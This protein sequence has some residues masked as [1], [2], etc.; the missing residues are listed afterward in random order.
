LT[1]LMRATSLR[2]VVIKQLIQASFSDQDKIPRAGS[3]NTMDGP[4][5]SERAARAVM[6]TRG[7]FRWRLW[8]RCYITNTLLLDREV[9]P[10]L[11]VWGDV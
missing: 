5:G 1:S 2:V 10:D 6:I 8:K 7:S 9:L 4:E 11:C 3:T